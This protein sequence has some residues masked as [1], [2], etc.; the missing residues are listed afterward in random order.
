[1]GYAFDLALTE[2]IACIDPENVRSISIATRLGFVRIGR[3]RAYGSE[4]DLYCLRLDK[5]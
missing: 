1:V 5:A 4:F 3:K 2:I